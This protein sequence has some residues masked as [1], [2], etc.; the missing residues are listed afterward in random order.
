MLRIGRRV[1]G[2]VGRSCRG[3]RPNVRLK[4]G[5]LDWWL[6]GDSRVS[7]GPL[8]S[9]LQGLVSVASWARLPS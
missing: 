5:R 6:S 3:M 1:Q 4:T 7:E 2:D 8:F 9:E